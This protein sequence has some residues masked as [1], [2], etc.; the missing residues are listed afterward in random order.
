MADIIPLKRLNHRLI[1]NDIIK[2]LKDL[3]TAYTGPYQSPTLM[4]RVVD[5]SLIDDIPTERWE[6]LTFHYRY[7]EEDDVFRVL[8]GTKLREKYVPEYGA[9][10]PV[11][12]AVIEEREDVSEHA[13]SYITKANIDN[14]LNQYISAFTTCDSSIS[15]WVFGIVEVLF[16]FDDI[17]VTTPVKDDNDLII[18]FYI[19]KDKRQF[20]LTFDFL[21]ILLDSL[22]MDWFSQNP[23]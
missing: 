14:T 11:I 23:Q 8:L 20:R 4:A 21:P 15:L 3:V 6:C 1:K 2:Q 16:T 10:L 17:E 5:V 19:R 7:D 18:D 13:P 22:A 9:Q 12:F